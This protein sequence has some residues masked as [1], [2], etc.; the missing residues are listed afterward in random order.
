MR[1]H[2]EISYLQNVIGEESVHSD[3]CFN[4]N[5]NNNEVNFTQEDRDFYH[6]LLDE[7]LNNSNGTGAFWIGDLDYFEN[8]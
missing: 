5:P 1:F 2:G 8:W 3:V 6:S 7:W 4:C